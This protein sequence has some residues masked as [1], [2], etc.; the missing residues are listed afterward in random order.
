MPQKGFTELQHLSH[1]FLS[2]HAVIITIKAYH[3]TVSLHMR[4]G[5]GIF[6]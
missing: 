4:V 6:G 3:K 2:I 5:K 1:A